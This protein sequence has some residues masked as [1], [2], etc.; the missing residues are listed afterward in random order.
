[1]KSLAPVMIPRSVSLPTASI[2]STPVAPKP[3]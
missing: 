3:V 2:P 1:M